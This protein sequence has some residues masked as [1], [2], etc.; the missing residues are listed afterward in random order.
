MLPGARAITD[1][2]DRGSGIST[3]GVLTGAANGVAGLG[4]CSLLA[5]LVAAAY[6]A[7][8]GLA[9][10]AVSFFILAAGFSVLR[11]EALVTSSAAGSVWQDVRSA[12]RYSLRHSNLRPAQVARTIYT[13]IGSGVVLGLIYVATAN[14]TR[15]TGTATVAVAAYAAGSAGGTLISGVR[16]PTRHWLGIA[17]GFSVLAAGAGLVSEGGQLLEIAGALLFGLGEG[18]ALLIFLVIRADG[19]PADFMSRIVGVSDVLGSVATSVVVAWMGITLQFLHGTG[20]FLL[21]AVLAVG[22]AGGTGLGRRTPPPST[23]S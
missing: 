15:S 21:V 20:A 3:A 4:C 7:A 5:G 14:G 6:G 18:S 16:S 11:I 22:L 13:A 1:S 12:L 2:T 9:T 10:D 23:A 8:A 19:I 17:I